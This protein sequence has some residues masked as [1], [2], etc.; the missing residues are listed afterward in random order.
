LC[1]RSIESQQESV[2]KMG[3]IVQTVLIEDQSVTERA[4]LQQAVPIAAIARQAGDFQSNHQ[5]SATHADV[6]HQSLKTLA[7]CGR[8][9]GLSQVAVD[10]DDVI[11]IP[12]ERDG[13][14]PESVLTFGALGVFRDLTQ[15]GLT[16]IKIGHPF[17]MPVVHFVHVAL[18]RVA[19]VG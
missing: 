12:A 9:P 19:S 11:G 8:S 5:P 6:A 1:I 2:V 10:D 4:N 13:T 17:Q 18:H 7:V 15:R 16:D 3:G 14:L